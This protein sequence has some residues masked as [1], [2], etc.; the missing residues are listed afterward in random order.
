MTIRRIYQ[1]TTYRLCKLLSL[2]IGAILSI[3]WGC[4]IV[5][6]PAPAYGMPYA[7]YQVSGTVLSSDQNL[8]VK[9]LFIS[10]RDT[11]ST[12]TA[13]DS[14]MTD[15]LGKY[16]LQISD[17]PW[18]PTWDLKVK[19]IDSIENGS[20]VTKDTIISIPSSALQGGDGKWYEGHAEKTVDLKIDKTN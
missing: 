4:G 1:K 11:G 6:P 3:F 10:I 17:G 12:L 13:R 5:D 16:S 15:S 9:G 8:P 14:T 7:K 20:F 18:N 19:D 2:A